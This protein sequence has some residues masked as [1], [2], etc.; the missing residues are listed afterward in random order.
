MKKF[1]AMLLTVLITAGMLSFGAME[2]GETIPETAPDEENLM[3][4]PE[5][6][7]PLEVE[8]A[9]ESI[10]K[11]AAESAE[12]PAEEPV[13]ELTEELPE[14]PVE[15]LVE[16]PA[17][18]PTAEAAEDPTEES[19]E[20]FVNESA[21][22][23]AVEI[24]EEPTEDAAEKPTE[25]FA[26]EPQILHA[27]D[28]DEA[29]LSETEDESADA[30]ELTEEEQIPAEPA[31]D[32]KAEPA[33]EE[34][35]EDAEEPQVIVLEGSEGEKFEDVDVREEPDG[36]SAIFTTLPEGAEVT[37]IA[38]EGD[39]V[40]VEVDG[41]IGYIYIDDLAAYLDTQKE[42]DEPE[43]VDPQPPKTEKKVTIFSSRRSMMT[44]GEP[45]VLTSK[46]EGF[47]GCEI[48]YTWTCDKHDGHGFQPVPGANSASYSFP[49]TAESLSWDW[50]LKVQSR[51][52]QN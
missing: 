45:V 46:L 21:E 41:E 48:R 16:E 5:T 27:E 19:A 32:E 13:E 29:E 6:E 38:V 26:E 15:E 1:L 30:T 44:E 52:A 51:P 50:Q 24:T 39:W 23:P 14:E 20:E 8:T 18:E 35:A 28:P 49:A 2:E 34:S 3:M 47:E 25:D 43:T 11:P 37:V 42:E 10:G 12:D 9:E 22:E 33:D 4:D 17:E 31:E 40:K 7:E 36:L